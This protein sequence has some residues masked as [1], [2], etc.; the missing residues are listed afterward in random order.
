MAETIEVKFRGD[1]GEYTGPERRGQQQSGDEDLR[2][3]E[4]RVT[5]E[6]RERVTTATLVG[7]LLHE[8]R[9]VTYRKAPEG[10]TD[11]DEYR[12]NILQEARG[13]VGIELV[14]AAVDI[15]QTD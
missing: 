4:D 3:T 11:T 12:E 8:K 7:H 13:N 6:I 1:G 9:K 15:Q 5:D 10:C 2:T 14:E